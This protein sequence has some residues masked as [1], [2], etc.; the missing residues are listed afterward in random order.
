MIK[1]TVEWSSGVWS[2]SIGFTPGFV[3]SMLANQLKFFIKHHL[4]RSQFESFNKEAVSKTNFQSIG[5]LQ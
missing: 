2:E 4:L 1:M 3:H 5:K